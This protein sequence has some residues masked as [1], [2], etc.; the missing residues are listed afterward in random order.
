MGTVYVVQNQ[1]KL[2]KCTQCLVPK[3]EFKGAKVYGELEFLLSPTA[4]PFSTGPLID[5]LKD[6]LRDF[7][8]EDHLLLVGNPVLIGCSMSIAAEANHGRVRVL[9][10][11]GKAQEYRSIS[12]DFCEGEE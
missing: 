6:K 3:F 11:S 2:D 8:D 7:S 10:W 9:Q 4:S 1:H 5:E 12:V